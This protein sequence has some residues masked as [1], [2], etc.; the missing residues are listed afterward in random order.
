MFTESKVTEIF[1]VADDFCKVFNQELLTLQLQDGKPHR[2]KPGILSDSEEKT[3]LIIFHS[4]SFPCLKQFPV[5]QTFLQ[6]VCM[7]TSWDIQMVA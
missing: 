2:N 3:I 5:P 4:N 1:C 6:R 7:G